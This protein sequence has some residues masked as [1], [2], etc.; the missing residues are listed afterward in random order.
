MVLMEQLERVKPPEPMDLKARFGQDFWERFDEF[1]KRQ[2]EHEE[3]SRKS[4][5]TQVEYRPEYTH[6][7]ITFESF[8][9]V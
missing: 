6:S 1:R 7:E 8:D 4:Q 9:C 2:R 5:M 3:L